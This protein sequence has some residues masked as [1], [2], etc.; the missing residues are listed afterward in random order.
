MLNEWEDSYDIKGLD[1]YPEY[2]ARKKFATKKHVLVACPRHGK[3]VDVVFSRKHRPICLN[4]LG[5]DACDF[6]WAY[7]L[8][9]KKD[10]PDS[11]KQQ[12]SGET[13]Y[14][15]SVRN[16]KNVKLQR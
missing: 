13:N 8:V 3:I 14:W 1:A 12:I 11:F 15:E 2:K 16:T 6:C 5:K 9:H 4:S 10:I 7:N